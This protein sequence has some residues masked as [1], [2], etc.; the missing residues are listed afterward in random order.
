MTKKSLCALLLAGLFCI[1]ASRACAAPLEETP[2]ITLTAPSCLL[3]D[4]DTGAVIF[5]KSADEQRPVASV[6]KLMTL[7]I[8]F[9]KLDGGEITPDDQ[10]T[11]SPNAAGQTG[12]QALLDANAVYPLK[13]L[14]RSTI[15]A[16]GNDSAVALAEYA[17]GTEEAFV[18][19]MNERAAALGL[20]NT[21]YKNCT[22][23]P[24]EG[25]H[26]TARDVAV[27]SREVCTHPDYF[28]YSGT[29]LSTLTHPG[30]RTTDLTNTN[31]LVRFYTGCDGLKTGSTNEAKYCMSATAVRNGMRL[32]AVVLGASTS[33]TRFSEARSMLDYGFATYSHAD[34]L[35]QDTPLNATVPVTLGAKDAVKA[36]PGGNLSMLLKSG[37]QKQL[38]F[39][40][41]LLPSVAAPVQKGDVLGE[42]TVLLSGRAVAKVPAVAAES[43]PLPG[44]LNG[45][46]RL[47]GNWK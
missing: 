29:W 16:S 19:L 30:G 37:Q 25:A 10:V 1:T 20:Q 33:Q 32:I 13:D 39:E 45:L 43:V 42:I 38:S 11:V 22:G 12:S 26:T 24:T 46:M 47:F 14:L 36:A 35:T 44:F 28:D 40:L 5:E 23:L 34:I 27:L 2:P 4:A 8:L 18:R 31:R 17:A 21:V 7:L 15:I 3:M 9:E 6:T 41:S